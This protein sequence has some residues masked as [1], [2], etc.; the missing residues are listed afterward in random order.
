MIVEL[1][2]MAGHHQRGVP[3][4]VPGAV[5]IGR[6][7][8]RPVRLRD[9]HLAR[10][11]R[12]AIRRPCPCWQF[13]PGETGAL[14][15]ALRGRPG[16]HG[17]GHDDPVR[18]VR[19]RPRRPQ[20]R[21]PGAQGDPQGR[22]G[23]AAVE[24]GP[25]AAILTATVAGRPAVR[26]AGDHE[27]PDRHRRRSPDL[28]RRRP[29]RRGVRAA[30]RSRCT[31][32]PRSR[33]TPGQADWAAIAKLKEHVAIPVYGNG[34]IWE[35]ADARGHDRPDRG[36]RG[37]HRPRLPRSALAVPRPGAG[38]SRGRADARPAD[39]RR[40]GDHDPRGT[41]SCWPG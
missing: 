35:A 33:P 2:P 40:G 1:A 41:P 21:L 14:G 34:D 8:R 38:A 30:R 37:G 23:G 24:A 20:L 22:R 13:D 16:D 18:R 32:G 36:R 5:P 28:S 11:G 25:A 19:G 29:D 39:A 12:A 17:P 3:A 15:P 9:D 31:V 4:A 10:A 7:H 27:D 26:R 6:R